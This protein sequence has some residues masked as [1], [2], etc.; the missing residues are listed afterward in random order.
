MS[1]SVIKEFS[2]A[3]AVFLFSMFIVGSSMLRGTIMLGEGYASY[4]LLMVTVFAIILTI[5]YVLFKKKYYHEKNNLRN[6]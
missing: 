6:R 5:A 2:E 1:N 4:D 3:I